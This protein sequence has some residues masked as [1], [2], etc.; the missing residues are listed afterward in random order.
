MN[1]LL[2]VTAVAVVAFG[3]WLVALR[4]MPPA[5]LLDA[6][7]N[8]LAQSAAEGYC[9]GITFWSTPNNKGDKKTMDKCLTDT[10]RPTE[11]NLSVVIA[12]FCSGITEAGY[13][14]GNSMCQDIMERERFWPTTDGRITN[15]WSASAPWPGDLIAAGG[16]GIDRAGGNSR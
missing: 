15:A 13:S 11:R 5:P 9:A 6:N 3:F 16:S 10:K 8:T 7:L 1:K 4:P 14:G 2:A 12:T